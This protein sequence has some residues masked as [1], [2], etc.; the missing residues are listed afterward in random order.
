MV[1]T[2][3][4]AT[5]LAITCRRPSTQ[6]KQRYSVLKNVICK[7]PHFITDRLRM[8]EHI[9]LTSVCLPKLTALIPDA[10][11]MAAI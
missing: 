7:L 4:Q 1:E 8:L 6:K 2:L 5:L 10:D 9:I 3:P 11:E